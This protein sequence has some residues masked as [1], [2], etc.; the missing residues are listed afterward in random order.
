ME[1]EWRTERLIFSVEW[2]SVD[3]SPIHRRREDA[4]GKNGVEGKKVVKDLTWLEWPVRDTAGIIS[5]RCTRATWIH[6]IMENT[7]GNGSIYVTSRTVREKERDRDR[8][9]DLYRR[10]WFCSFGHWPFQ[11]RFNQTDEQPDRQTVARTNSTRQ[12]AAA[13]AAGGTGTRVSCYAVDETLR[14]LLANRNLIEA[15][16]GGG[17]GVGGGGYR[18]E[19]RLAI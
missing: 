18:G 9:T 15:G 10:D 11:G 7:M 3:F 17:V 2:N 6:A 14:N 13:A 12:S 8:Q 4:G 19:T 16:A 1:N 5:L